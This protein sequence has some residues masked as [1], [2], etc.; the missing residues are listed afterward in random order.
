MEDKT[1]KLLGKATIFKMILRHFSLHK[2]TKLKTDTSSVNNF[3]SLHRKSGLGLMM[4]YTLQHMS[5]SYKDISVF[6]RLNVTY[7]GDENLFQ[8]N[9][10]F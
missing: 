6:S 1:P 8:I 5:N 10:F 3:D 7:D 4:A 2:V 9:R